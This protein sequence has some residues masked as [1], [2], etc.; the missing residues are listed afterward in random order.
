MLKR[1]A[2]MLVILMTVVAG[3][4]ASAFFILGPGRETS[5]VK[6]ASPEQPGHPPGYGTTIPVSGTTTL[7][8]QETAD[9]LCQV[10]PAALRSLTRISS[11]AGSL[12]NLRDGLFVLDQ[13][14]TRLSD[15]A[16]GRPALKPLIKDLMSVRKS[17]AAAIT[18]DDN[19]HHQ[20]AVA[21]ITGANKRLEAM[22]AHLN[23]A[24]P[25]RNGDCR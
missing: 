6:S 22:G 16:I 17:W 7:S 10:Q 3:V 8:Q 24:F 20:Q 9:A 2:G 19:K 1:R 13:R 21:A 25:H 4:A 11:K 23:T 18:A 12:E 15:A 5:P 14:I